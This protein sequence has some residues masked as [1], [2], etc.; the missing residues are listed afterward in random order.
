[1]N[2][3]TLI[4]F[5]QYFWFT[6][7]PLVPEVI[8][9][10]Q[11]FKQIQE[12]NKKL[13]KKSYNSKY[14]EYL[15]V[16]NLGNIIAPDFITKHF[17]R[18]LKNSDLKMIRFYD[19]RHSCASLLLERGITLKEIQAWLGHS[20]FNTTANI[21]AHLDTNVKQKSANVLSNILN[22]QKNI[23]TYAKVDNL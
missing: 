19:L 15:C 4:F 10:L 20:N 6:S 5:V 23:P 12:N 2:L 1:M 18:L 8:E 17:K 22:G 13:Y 21:Y 3:H 14:K 7:L 11:K 16:D 9:V